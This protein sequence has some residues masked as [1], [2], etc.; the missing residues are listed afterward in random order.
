MHSR[1]CSI[2]KVASST[3]VYIPGKSKKRSEEKQCVFFI[4]I[5]NFRDKAL[6]FYCLC[7]RFYLNLRILA[8]V[9]CI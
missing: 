1:F 9:M 8:G 7:L 4:C 3:C 6:H 5:S 2:D